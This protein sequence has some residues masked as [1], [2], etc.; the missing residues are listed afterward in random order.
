MKLF[1][2]FSI[3]REYIESGVG[4]VLRVPALFILEAWYKSD[5]SAAIQNTSDDVKIIAHAV[6][7]GSKSHPER[8]N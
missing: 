6:Y 5:P 1:G 8:N 2:R 4:V 3:P 7:Y